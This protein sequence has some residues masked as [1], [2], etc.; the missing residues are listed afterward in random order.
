MSVS[1]G[2]GGEKIEGDPGMVRATMARGRKLTDAEAR[3]WRDLLFFL[4]VR[5][6]QLS[7]I[8]ATR[9]LNQGASSRDHLGKRCRQLEREAPDVAN[10]FNPVGA[11]NGGH[12]R[13]E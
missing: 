7:P 1:R 3:E 8:D 6:A 12:R 10:L 9:V 5:R 13:A 11:G 2:F 4:M